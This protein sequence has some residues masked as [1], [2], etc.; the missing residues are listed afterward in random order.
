MI[1]CPPLSAGGAHVTMAAL[2]PAAAATPL[3]APGGRTPTWV[4]RGAGRSPA[5]PTVVVVPA[6]VSTW[7]V[8][9]RRTASS[10]R[11]SPLTSV[12]NG[13]SPGWPSVMGF[14]PARRT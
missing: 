5:W 4:P 8:D 9:G 14:Q 12:A 2:V 1:V 11:A 7:P 6:E 10:A 3:G 13:T